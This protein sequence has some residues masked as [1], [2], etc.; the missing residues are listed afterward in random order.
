MNRIL[1]ILSIVV[2][3]LLSACIV[4]GVIISNVM[5]AKRVSILEQ[6][7]KY[8]LTYQKNIEVYE[9]EKKKIDEYVLINNERLA[10]KQIDLL[11]NNFKI[12][13]SWNDK[14]KDYGNYPI[15]IQKNDILLINNANNIDYRERII[16]AYLILLLQIREKSNYIYIE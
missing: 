7:S 2:I 12:K 16:K 6:Q 4:E 8:Y 13:N 11:I 5:Y 3:V 14:Y 10:N 9:A 1:I 15:I